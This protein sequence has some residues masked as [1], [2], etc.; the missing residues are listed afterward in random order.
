V[1]LPRHGTRQEEHLVHRHGH[2]RSL[3]AEHDHGGGVADED[4]LDAG[5]FGEARA[6]RV[7][8]GDHDDG[9]AALLHRGELG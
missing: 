3:V 2:G 4:H 8:G 9:V 5:V 6:G 1:R 7:V